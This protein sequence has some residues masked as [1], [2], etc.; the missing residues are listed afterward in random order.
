MTTTTP[1][2]ATVTPM[3]TKTQD[4]W[5]VIDSLTPALKAKITRADNKLQAQMMLADKPYLDDYR[6]V[7]DENAPR[8]DK[9]ISEARAK[10]D[11]LIAQAEAEFQ[12]ARD[13]AQ[14]E[15]EVEVKPISDTYNRKS[16]EHYRA[17]V[18]A[19]R[20]LVAEVSGQEIA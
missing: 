17:Y 3:Q 8:R 1:F 7:I 14:A 2:A 19:W 5:K 15:F 11:A 20:A 9:K 4:A 13:E 6:Q 12:I 16:V 10:R 18:A